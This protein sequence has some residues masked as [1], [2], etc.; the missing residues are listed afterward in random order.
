MREEDYFIRSYKTKLSS[1]VQLEEYTNNQNSISFNSFG[2]S[3]PTLMHRKSISLPTI[4]NPKSK[5]I[6]KYLSTMFKESK[7]YI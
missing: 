6:K 7:F 4:N 1:S 5:G 3:L 2:G